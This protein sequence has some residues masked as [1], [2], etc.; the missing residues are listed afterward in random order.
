LAF[1]EHRLHS[2]SAPE[3]FQTFLKRY[4]DSEEAT[5]A[6]YFLGRIAESHAEWPVARSWYNEIASHFPNFFYAALARERLKHPEISRA[7]DSPGVAAFLQSITFAP[8]NRLPNLAPGE[9]NRA[10][11]DRAQLLSAAGLDDLA[12]S[13]LMFSAKA[14]GQPELAGFE[15]AE[16]AFRRGAPDQAIRYIK[17]TA[18]DYLRFAADATPQKF[19]KLAFPLPYRDTL[20]RYSR[21]EGLDPFLVA[22][23]IRQ[24]SGFNTK[25]VSHA[26]AYGLTQVLPST[27]RQISRRVGL[28]GFHSGM[29]FT[30]DVNIR[31][32]TYYLRTLLDRL[33]G[34]W[35]ATLASYNAGPARVAQWL[36]RGTYSEP[37]EFIESIP[38][39]ETRDYVKSVLRNADAYRRFY[40][41]D[42]S[43]Y[44]LTHDMES[45][46]TMTLT[47]P[48]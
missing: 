24:E 34:N 38:F 29:L 44:A 17:Q 4:P 8:R 27:G 21:Q 25:A 37:A 6:M 22:G 47:S 13:E 23:V 10:R 15:A 14:D 9:A 40:G 1:G 12:E 19:W 39:D 7:S 2:S 33:Q 16:I 43:T 41:N 32:G 31:I 20:E 5:A 46:G 3:L 48:K 42:N 30:P 45:K 36:A 26:N 18:P 11:M 35:N 28:R